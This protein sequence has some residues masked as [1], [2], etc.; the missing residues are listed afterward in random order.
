VENIGPLGYHNTP[1]SRKE[2]AAVLS[3]ANIRKIIVKI[4]YKPLCFYPTISSN[5]LTDLSSPECTAKATR[6]FENLAD[7]KYLGNCPS[8]PPFV[9]F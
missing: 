2:H 5:L 6:V 1:L 4:C 9:S 7:F 3:S 8:L